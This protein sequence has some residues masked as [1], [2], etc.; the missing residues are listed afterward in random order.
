MAA[1]VALNAAAQ[2][3]PAPVIYENANIVQSDG[4]VLEGATLIVRG[5]RIMAVLESSGAGGQRGRRVDLAGAYITPGFIDVTDAIANTASGGGDASMRAG[6]AFDRYATGSIK[7][8]LEQGITAGFVPARGGGGVN[9]IGAVVR[10]VPGS[11]GAFG[12]VLVD[13]SALCVNLGSGGSAISRLQTFEAIRGTF[14]GALDYRES[15]AIYEEEL[16]EYERKLKERAEKESS[17]EDDDEDAEAGGEGGGNGNG[18]GANARQRRPGGR[19][20]PAGNAF[21]DEDE[22]GNGNGQPQRRGRGGGQQQGNA[23]K[24]DELKKPEQP[25][26]NAAFE[27]ILRAIDQELPVRVVAHGSADIFNAIELANE[28]DL[29]IIIEGGRESGAVAAALSAADVSV[30]LDYHSSAGTRASDVDRPLDQNIRALEAH[31]VEWCFGSGRDAGHGGRFPADARTGCIAGERRITHRA[32]HHR[33]CIVPRRVIRD[34]SP[35]RRRAG[36]FRHLVSASIGTRG[37]SARGLCRWRTRLSPGIGQHGGWPVSMVRSMIAAGVA[38]IVATAAMADTVLIAP[39]IVMPDGTLASGRAIVVGDDGIIQA[40]VDA[41]TVADDAN[42]VRYEQGVISAGLIDVNSYLGV[43]GS[44]FER[45][46]AIDAEAAVIDSFDPDAIELR[47]ALR[48]GVTSAM[49][50]PSPV[51]VMPGRAATVRTWS[52]GNDVDVLAEEAALSVVLAPSAYS[53]NREPSTRAGAMQMLRSMLRDRE[54]LPGPVAAS[55]IG[56]LPMMVTCDEAQDVFAVMALLGPRGV[57]LT[58][59]HTMDAAEIAEDAAESDATVVVGPYD[60]GSDAVTLSGAAALDNAGVP[61]VISG[62][63]GGG[64][65]D[66]LRISAALAVQHGLSPE[67]GRRAMTS[68]AATVAGV[69]ETTGSITVGLA[70][71]LVVFSADPLRLDSKVIDVWVK[72]ER[73]YSAPSAQYDHDRVIGATHDD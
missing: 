42:I 10:F 60:F 35:W 8:A 31:G 71:D 61:V 49:I 7:A 38:G 3:G 2:F 70:A 18:Q 43:S 28:F 5:D 45:A 15:L 47:R 32:S 26:Y 66:R 67:A 44:N 52:P 64:D 46:Q 54:N 39:Q 63:V 27:T 29:K 16:E 13:E 9:G 41:E 40:I 20:R 57:S 17:E 19:G 73:A 34:W 69:A 33:C 50:A 59:V 6:D 51:N 12:E 36:R 4:A 24:D 68:A 58:I 56:A 11:G 37:Q 62:Q 55:M 48:A 72:G 14:R 23:D 22:E 65:P 25:Q 30:V 1:A 53:P 21:Q